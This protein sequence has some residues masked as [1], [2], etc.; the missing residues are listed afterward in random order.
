M[1]GSGKNCDLIEVHRL[2]PAPFPGCPMCERELKVPLPAIA[3]LRIP[4]TTSPWMSV[5]RK[6]RPEYR[7]GVGFTRNF[8]PPGEIREVH[9]LRG[10]TFTQVN[11]GVSG[12]LSHSL[13]PLYFGLGEV[14]GVE[15]VEVTWPSGG[16]QVVE[17]LELGKRHTIQEL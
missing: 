15:K 11:D 8:G 10:K 12:Y 4:R 9:V 7:L 2:R 1:V 16:Q 6:S 5:R 13:I 14:G 3:Q 17:G